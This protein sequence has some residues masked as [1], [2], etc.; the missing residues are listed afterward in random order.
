MQSLIAKSNY[1][2]NSAVDSNSET[3]TKNK[4]V[5]DQ[6]GATGDNFR[7]GR[8]DARY[9]ACE[10][11]AVH[12]AKVLSG[13]DSTLSQT[14]YDCQSQGAMLIEGYF[15]CNPLALGKVLDFY[16][17]DNSSIQLSDM[18]LPGIYIISFWNE[19]PLKNGLHTVA[20][21]YDGNTYTTYNLG[22]VS[23]QNPNEYIHQGYFICGYKVG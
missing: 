21:S 12:N 2:F 14:M 17:I 9:N 10:T 15:G 19:E 20:V 4:L 23:T 8:Y 6:N 1:A 5:T 13:M 22:G 7:F 11:I 18:N 3:T 16:G